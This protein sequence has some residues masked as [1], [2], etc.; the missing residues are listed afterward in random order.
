MTQGQPPPPSP[1]PA[2]PIIAQQC[3]PPF[4]SPSVYPG[5]LP[6]AGGN[7]PSG[8]TSSSG[9]MMPLTMTPPPVQPP[10][11]MPTEPCT[12]P[13][14]PV[15]QTL[16]KDDDEDIA[17]DQPMPAQTLLPARRPRA[18][19][20]ADPGDAVEARADVVPVATPVEAPVQV[21]P[22]APAVDASSEGAVAPASK[23]ARQYDLPQ[24]QP[25]QPMPHLQPPL[26]TSSSSPAALP[27]LHRRN[28]RRRNTSNSMT[29]TMMIW[30]W[31]HS[32]HCSQLILLY[33]HFVNI[34]QLLQRILRLAGHV[35]GRTVKCPM[36]LLFNILTLLLIRHV[37]LNKRKL[38]FPNLL[39]LHLI[40]HPEVLP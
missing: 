11:P 24:Q 30:L 27:D 31:I 5:S 23:K 7:F 12:S 10:M 40:R 22:A 34:N 16:D 33:S 25:L 14:P 37:N 35:A 18:P 4:C 19:S 21:V 9:G 13:A 32:I 39:Y 6:V 29:R 1:P 15:V 17:E 38:L 20:I 36:L 28:L 3:M 8:E 2:A 26:P